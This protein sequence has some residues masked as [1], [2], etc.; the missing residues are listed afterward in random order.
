MLKDDKF[1]GRKQDREKGK[2]KKRSSY[3][4]QMM[5]VNFNEKMIIEQKFEGVDDPKHM[6]I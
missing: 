3:L 5:Q 1:C 4:N 6:N 2:G